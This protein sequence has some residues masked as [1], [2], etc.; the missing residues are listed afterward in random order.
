MGRRGSSGLSPGRLPSMRSRDL[1]LGGVKKKTFTPNIIGRKVKEEPKGVDGGQR[2]DRREDRG[3]G[4]RDR[5]RGRGRAEVIQS[6]SI[7]EQGPAEMMMK[8]KGLYE[9]ERDA[10]SVGPSPIINIKKEYR[11]TEEE[12]KEHLRKLERDNFID[13]PYLK[14]ERRSCPVQLPLAVSG[15]GFKE[16]FSQVKTEKVEEDIEPMETLPEVKQEPVEKVKKTEETFR[17]PP[18][19]EPDVLPDLLHQWSLSK[20]EELFFM[21]LPDSLPGQPPTRE[22]KP[23]KTEVQSETGQPMLL[24]AESQE[25]ETDE[26]SCNLKDLREG[27]VGKMLVRKSGRV[28]LILGQVTLDVSLG[29]TCSF[30][31]ELVSV[32]TEGKTGDLTV[33]GHIKHKMVCSPDF[34]ALLQSS[35]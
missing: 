35:A 15:W 21:Q 5:G 3:R 31:Q 34:E 18:L 13:D 12:T 27:I 4:Q 32:G 7:F 26:N 1:T 17:P 30:L 8:K 10:P 33:L 6:H 14:S 29:T 28:Q 11:E 23:L 25:D 16:E 24:K 9:S 22:S 2:R 19:P 20:G